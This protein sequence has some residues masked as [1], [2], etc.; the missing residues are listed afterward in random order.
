MGHERANGHR[1][2][3]RS[4]H[5]QPVGYAGKGAAV[6]TSVRDDIAS[7]DLSDIKDRIVEVG[8]KLVH[9]AKSVG[10]E[11]SSAPARRIEIQRASDD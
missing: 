7:V 11:N 3:F 5:Y 4:D 6:A 1:T 9:K 8:E 10:S 2:V